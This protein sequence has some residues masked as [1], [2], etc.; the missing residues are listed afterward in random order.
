MG[1]YV[2]DL[3]IT[4]GDMEVLR[5]FKREM[6]KNFKMSDLGVL[7][8]YLGIEVQQS[9]AGIT[10]FQGAYA[11][12]LLDTTGLVDSNPT[13]TPMEARLQLRKAGTTSTVG[14]VSR[15]MEAPRE[16][17][18]VAVKRILRYVARTKGWGVRYCAERGKEKLELVGYSNSDMVGDV[19][20][21]KSTSGMIYFLSGTAIC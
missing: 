4:G 7:S 1:V 15:F 9:T 2:E 16:E 18:L 10:I 6:S 17:H 19:D 20:D 11:K 14:Y 3:I 5:R 8:Y 13:R 12:K 21:R